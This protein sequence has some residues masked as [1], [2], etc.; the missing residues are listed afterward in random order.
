[1]LI[2]LVNGDDNTVKLGT[3]AILS[4]KSSSTKGS[5]LPSGTILMWSGT[6]T[7]IPDG[8]ALCNG[9]NGTPNLTGRFIMGRAND[10]EVATGGA[11]TH[12]HGGTSGPL[13]DVPQT[14]AMGGLSW[15]FG[16]VNH[17]HNVGSAGHL[18]PYYLLAFIIKL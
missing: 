15:Q 16:G 5:P 3:G 6:I 10:S 14:T 11:S 1:L 7:T 17:Y 9:Q 18:P 4:Q 13:G 2:A 8:W 12:D